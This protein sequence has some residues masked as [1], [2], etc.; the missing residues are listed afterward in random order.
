MRLALERVEEAPELVHAAHRRD[1]EVERREPRPTRAV[2][3]G[4]PVP[5]A[6]LVSVLVAVANGERYLRQALESVLRQSVADLELLVVDDGSTDGTPGHPRG[7]R[8]RPAARPPPRGAPRPRRLAEPRARRGARALPRADGRRRRRPAATGSRA[9][10]RSSSPARASASSGRGPR[11]RRGRPP[12][13]PAR[14]RARPRRDALA[15]AL[16]RPRLPRHGGARAGA[17]RAQRPSLRHRLRR[18]RGL[19]PVDAAPR[20][21]RGRRRRGAARPPPA[22]SRPGV[23]PPRRAAALARAR[24]LAPRDRRARALLPPERAELARRVALG[25]ELRRP[26]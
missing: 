12:R 19:R 26:R 9:A 23:P 22:P 13:A 3:Y 21:H 14:P 7:G 25:R 4:T 5:T 24:G 15:R 8:G 11:H 18:E 6:P 1:D 16:Q 10:W 17:P 2:G 20:G